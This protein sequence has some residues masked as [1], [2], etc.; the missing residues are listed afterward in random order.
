MGSFILPDFG[1]TPPAMLTI[2]TPFT[3]DG[4]IGGVTLP[5]G[6]FAPDLIFVGRGIATIHLQLTGPTTTYT[7]A[8]STY[9]FVAT[10]EPSAIGLVGLG[11]GALLGGRR[12]F[13]SRGK[14]VV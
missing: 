5:F 1:P 11:L 8:G 6:G 7:Y 10:P 13:G 12:A 2:T 3:S 4:G 14:R 9:D